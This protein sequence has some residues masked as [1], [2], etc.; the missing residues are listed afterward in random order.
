MRSESP[1]L[2]KVEGREPPRAN[3]WTSA[4]QLLFLAAL[5]RTRSVTRAAAAAG[6]SR[7]SAYRLRARDP[8]GL[9]AALWDRAIVGHRLVNIARARQRHAHPF[10]G[11]KSHKVD[12]VYEPGFSVAPRS[13]S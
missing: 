9:F 5:A 6:M 8:H 2:S 1:V 12:E 10:H 4:R 13:T 7:E 11:R 3:G